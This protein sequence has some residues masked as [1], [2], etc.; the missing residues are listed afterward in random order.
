MSESLLF[1]LGGIVLMIAIAAL[2]V[3]GITY[4]KS[5]LRIQIG[6]NFDGFDN[7]E[8]KPGTPV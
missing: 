6:D 8:N 5:R 1:G 3:Y 7:V 2:A 4:S